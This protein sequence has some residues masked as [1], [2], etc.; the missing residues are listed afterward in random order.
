VQETHP[1]PLHLKEIQEDGADLPLLVLVKQAAA[2]VVLAA[3]GVAVIQ[4][5]VTVVLV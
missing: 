2:V 3:Q 1:Q 5:L 4:V